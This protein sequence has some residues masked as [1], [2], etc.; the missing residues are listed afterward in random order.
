MAAR[1][2]ETVG[3]V[4][5][6]TVLYGVGSAAEENRLSASFHH[7][8]LIIGASIYAQDWQNEP[9][10]VVQRHHLRRKIL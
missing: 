3:L 5:L 10:I 2:C 6:L 7:Y 8:V 1:T 4:A 9:C